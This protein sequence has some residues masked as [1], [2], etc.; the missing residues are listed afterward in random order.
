MEKRIVQMDDHTWRIE[1]IDKEHTSSVYSYLLEGKEKALLIDTGLGQIDLLETVRGLTNK[2]VEAICTHAHFDH[3][4]ANPFFEKVWINELDRDAYKL[5]TTDFRAVFPYYS[6]A[7]VRNNIEWYDGEPEF[8]LG[9]RHI[10]VILT[11]G[12]TLGH[13]ALLDR[14]HRWLFTGDSCCK[15]AVLLNLPHTTSVETYRRSIAKLLDMRD[16]YDIT[17]PAHHTLPVGTD[18]LE[19]FLTACDDLLSQKVTAD[20]R[21][22]P[23][24]P[25]CIYPYK[26]ISIHYK[27]NGLF[28]AT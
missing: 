16:L 17:W 27:K 19:Q 4:G 2:P 12:H 23:F 9:E 8:D 24:G 10:K 7:D 3:I 11:P 28:D 26:D 6:Y 20:D 1:E 5:H 22:T 18:V 21:E 14:E 25:T 15:E 13:I